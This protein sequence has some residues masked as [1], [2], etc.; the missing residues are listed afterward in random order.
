MKRPPRILNVFAGAGG[1]ALGFE[2]AGFAVAAAIEPDPVHAATF[3][4]NFAKT[5]VHC[6]PVDAATLKS[7]GERDFDVV[8]G[9]LPS[10]A[11][12]NGG[13]RDPDDDR[14]HLLDRFVEIVLGVQ[15][16]AFAL[17]AV[18]GILAPQ[19]AGV[20]RR[21][22]KALSSRGYATPQIW[23]LDAADFALPQTRKRVWLVGTRDGLP[24]PKTPMRTVIPQ[25]RRPAGLPVL[26]REGLDAGPTVWDAIGDLPD[27][28]EHFE[29]RTADRRRLESWPDPSPWAAALRSG[30]QIG[31]S[32]AREVD[33]QLLT[34]S[35]AT[36]H[37][38]ASALRYAQTAPGSAE[39]VS[40]FYR[41]H[42]DGLSRTLR[43]GT[44]RDRG[45]FTGAR[46]STPPNRE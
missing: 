14:R 20:V 29:L 31:Y 15:P 30:N 3:K 13:R 19:N 41:L 9:G 4:R 43:A 23:H 39:P 16:E 18:P 21:T 24:T 7:L 46:P 5:P 33:P 27:P 10:S 2:Q 11:F 6:G 8:A 17:E 40:R 22:M 34:A 25:H 36:R 26:P 12:S 42:P 28:Q 37:T 44:G 38:M 45:A 1:L 35:Q 32:P